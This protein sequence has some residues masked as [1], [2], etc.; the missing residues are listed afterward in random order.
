M[1]HQ[2][3]RD[4]QTDTNEEGAKHPVRSYSPILK[5]GSVTLSHKTS[6]RK[7]MNVYTAPPRSYRER[8]LTSNSRFTRSN[9]LVS[10]C[11]GVLI[12]DAR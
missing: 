6:I 10:G 7:A 1:S 12:T 4:S 5:V 3:S 2:W 8:T 11:V 9:F